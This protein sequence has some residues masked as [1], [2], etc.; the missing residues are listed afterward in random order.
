MITEDLLCYS[1]SVT[2]WKKFVFQGVKPKKEKK[3]VVLCGDARH[4]K[5]EGKKKKKKK[6]KKSSRGICV[7]HV[8]LF[9][10]YSWPGFSQKKLMSKFR[11]K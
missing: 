2:D 3:I 10:A 9:Q 6:E 4:E 7:V 5:K 8:S 11:P 1:Q